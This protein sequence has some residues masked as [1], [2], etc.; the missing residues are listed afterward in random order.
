VRRKCLL[1][2][3]IKGNIKGKKKGWEDEEGDVSRYWI[4][5]RKRK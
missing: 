4:T 1:R 2:Y 3:V 5:L